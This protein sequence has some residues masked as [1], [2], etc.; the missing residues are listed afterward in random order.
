VIQLERL[1]V[2]F[3]EL[4]KLEKNKFFIRVLLVYHLSIVLT[5]K[6]DDL[7]LKR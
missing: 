2:K 6:E 7:T 4:R 3:A 1:N 5:L